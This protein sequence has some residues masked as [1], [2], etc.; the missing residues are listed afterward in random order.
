M[1]LDV[2]FKGEEGIGVGPTHEFFSLFSEE[3]CKNCRGIWRSDT[4]DDFAFAKGGLFPRP[5][6]PRDLMY[7]AGILCAKAFSMNSVLSFDFNP[8]FFK[9]LRGEKVTV[10]EIDLI[11]ANSLKETQSLFDLPF[12]Y[13][14]IPS[15][16]MSKKHSVTNAE[17]IDEYVALVHSYTCGK[18][19]SEVMGAFR[20]GFSK[21]IPY[22]A[23]LV[24]TDEEICRLLRGNLS[25]LQV[26]DFKNHVS[27]AHGYEADSPQ[28]SY[29]FE[30]IS[31]FCDD[32]KSLFVKFVTGSR[33][34]PIGGLSVLKPKLTVAMRMMDDVAVDASFPSVM[35][36]ANYLKLPPYSTK[37]VLRERLLYA[38][39]ECQNCF[40]LT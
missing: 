25:K 34:L 3:M 37:E 27:A 7:L 8:A 13:P 30:V 9:Y 29:L 5:D 15:I 22:S 14:G 17:N 35:T 39:R 26:E 19:L 10:D 1:R 6:A 12:T 4:T 40:D 28:I 16:V 32:D 18:K 36:C 20:A 31:E 33:T 11:L 24:F 2:R 38:I 23:M 21:V